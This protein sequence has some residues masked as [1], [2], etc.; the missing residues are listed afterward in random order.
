MSERPPWATENV[1]PPQWVRALH[2][3]VNFT[4]LQKSK[5]S[6]QLFIKSAFSFGHGHLLTY[7][8]AVT[9]VFLIFKYTFINTDAVNSKS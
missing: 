8:T 4:F 7:T 3:R 1:T 5:F 9:Q 6:L 2:F